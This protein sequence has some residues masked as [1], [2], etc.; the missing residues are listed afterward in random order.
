MSS[1]STIHTPPSSDS[2][3]YTPYQHQI[4]Q[5]KEDQA[6]VGIAIV[7]KVDGSFF[8]VFL[9]KE[10]E[11]NCTKLTIHSIVDGEVLGK[12]IAYP[13]QTNIGVCQKLP[14]YGPRSAKIF[15]K[16]L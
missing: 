7:R 15:I 5:L 14:G 10:E 1:I 11:N 8:P 6:C 3:D 4:D 16:Y 2:F 13:A 9:R 12:V